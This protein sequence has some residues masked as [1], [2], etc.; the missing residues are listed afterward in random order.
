V[1]LADELEARA[2]SARTSGTLGDQQVPAVGRID[3]GIRRAQ[4]P[5]VLEAVLRRGTCRTRAPQRTSTGPLAHAGRRSLRAGRSWTRGGGPPDRV[6][7][8]V[9]VPSSRPRTARSVSRCG[10][11]DLEAA[12]DERT[13]AGE[14]LA[15]RSARPATEAPR[16]KRGRPASRSPPPCGSNWRCRLPRRGRRSARAPARRSAKPQRGTTPPRECPRDV[17]P[18]PA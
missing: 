17:R 12:D 9:V 5:R 4:P 6:G 3:P 2:R 1:R 14:T 13:E 10:V 18:A 8:Q 7:V 16:L 11:R 15:I